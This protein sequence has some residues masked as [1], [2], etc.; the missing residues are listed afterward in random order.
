M[1]DDQSVYLEG[2]KAVL[3]SSPEMRVAGEASHLATA[4]EA[5]H[6]LRPVVTGVSLDLDNGEGYSILA[7]LKRAHA[8]AR[9]FAM[10]RRADGPSVRRALQ[11]GATGY[12]SKREDSAALRTAVRF[13]AENRRYLSVESREQL[14]NGYFSEQLTPREVQILSSA[15]EGNSN[16]VIAHDLGI[17]EGTVK[18]HVHQILKKL[19]MADRT[20]AVTR[21][22]QLGLITVPARPGAMGRGSKGVH[23]VVMGEK[24]L[25]PLPVV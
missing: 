18:S 25:T 9:L 1:I 13:T 19:G 22:L 12:Y 14:L 7:A 24:G 6:Q 4:I 17:T 8:G 15:A 5:F 11:A 20:G 16:K 23:P 3:S 21:A 2:A 10:G